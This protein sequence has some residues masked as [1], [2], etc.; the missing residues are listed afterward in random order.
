MLLV[1]RFSQ[2][3]AHEPY[4][5]VLNFGVLTVTRRSDNGKVH[6]TAASSRETFHNVETDERLQSQMS[7]PSENRLSCS[8]SALC[9]AFDTTTITTTSSVALKNDATSSIVLDLPIRLKDWESSPPTAE[10][11]TGRTQHKK[12]TSEILMEKM[13]QEL[14]AEQ[15]E[16]LRRRSMMGESLIPD[17]TASPVVNRIRLA[18][19]KPVLTRADLS[20]EEEETDACYQSDSDYSIQGER[21]ICLDIGQRIERENQTSIAS[22]SPLQRSIPLSSDRQS[23]VESE[24]DA[25]STNITPFIAIPSAAAVPLF[26]FQKCFNETNL[27][28]RKQLLASASSAE[29]KFESGLQHWLLYMNDRRPDGRIWISCCIKLIVANISL[30]EPFTMSEV[31]EKSFQ[32]L[33]ASPHARSLRPQSVSQHV[34]STKTGEKS[35][36]MIGKIGRKSKGIFSSSKMFGGSGSSSKSTDKTVRNP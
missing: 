7:F 6:S 25:D 11:P 15:D 34:L 24:D 9:A 12:T 19:I 3:V 1:D 32:H 28:A 20:S 35:A 21:D 17:L 33:A 22:G 4:A 31:L 30:V 27:T 23:Q 8:E 10:Y 29:R 2:T 18:E 36:V 14:Q 26:N 5:S 16:D 13:L